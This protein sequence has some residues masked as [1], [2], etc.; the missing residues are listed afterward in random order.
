MLFWVA[1]NK[2]KIDVQELI[3]NRPSNRTVPS[4]TAAAVPLS[5]IPL[6]V[7]LSHDIPSSN[8]NND[9]TTTDNL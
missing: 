6:T 2:D 7:S 3:I 9:A 5:N 4:T 1:S 8:R